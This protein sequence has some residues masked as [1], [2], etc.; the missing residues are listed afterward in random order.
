MKTNIKKHII[1]QM[2]FIFSII[3]FLQ[4]VNSYT[5]ENSPPSVILSSYS[6]SGN[7][8]TDDIIALNLKFTNTN[9]K[10]DVYDVLISYKSVNDLFLP[11]YGTSN[12]FIIPVIPAGSSIEYKL[13]LSV[14]RIVKN[15]GPYAN[16]YMEFDSIFIDKQNGVNSNSFIISDI[17]KKENAIQLLGIDITDI[18]FLSRDE[19]I[20]S[21]K[22]TV[23]NCSNSSV[24]NVFMVLEGNSPD[25]TIS[26]PLYDID[27][28]KHNINEF[29]LTLSSIGISEIVAT[30]N[31]NDI[32]GTSY[33]SAPQR[34]SVYLDNLLAEKSKLTNSA[35]PIFR[36]IGFIFCLLLLAIWGLILFINLRKKK[37]L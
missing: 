7:S 26:L 37:S 12:Q 20:F 21:F 2:I 27:P 31:Y 6:I 36:I 18:N 13:N 3:F 24:H 30:F 19:I 34:I 5:D 22:T 15:E 10:L 9:L 8:L 16:L 4:S 33:I 35:R 25:F 17:V 28:G 11:V 14:N 29:R 23:L 32:K 1:F